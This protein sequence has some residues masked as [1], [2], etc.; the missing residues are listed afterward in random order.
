LESV[1]VPR[2]S[3]DRARLRVALAQLAEQDPLINVRQNDAR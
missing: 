1:V 2:D 3:D